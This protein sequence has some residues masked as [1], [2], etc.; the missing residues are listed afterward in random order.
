[1]NPATELCSSATKKVV[2]SSLAYPGVVNTPKHD[3]ADS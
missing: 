3:S 2:G 1:M